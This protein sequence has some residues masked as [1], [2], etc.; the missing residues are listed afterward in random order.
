MKLEN[1]KKTEYFK[2]ARGNAQ[3]DIISPFLF[4]LGY[5]ILLFKLNFDLQILGITDNLPGTP[6]APVIP[7]PN[8]E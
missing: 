5:Q 6:A 3:G 8:R 1:K 2:L 7:D 4:L